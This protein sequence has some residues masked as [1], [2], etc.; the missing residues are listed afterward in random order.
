MEKD[1]DL[2]IFQHQLKFENNEYKLSSIDCIDNYIITGDEKGNIYSYDINQ[3]G[4]ATLDHTQFVQKGKIEQIKCLTPLNLAYI[5]VNG[6]LFG[7]QIPRLDLKF[8]FEHKEMSTIY[9][10]CLN[11]HPQCQN[12]V[13][14]VTKKRKVKCFEYLPEVAKLVEMKIDDLLL[15][16]LTEVMEWY[17]NWF[18]YAV[19]K[20]VF[21][22]NVV[23]G[24]ALNQDIES[25]CIKNVSGSWLI[26][27]NSI[28]LL[29]EQNIPKQQNPIMFSNKPL[30]TLGV[31]KNY[32]ISLHD[33]LIGVFDANDSSQVQE[34][35]LETGSTGKYLT[36]G[37]KRLFYVLS[38][39]SDKKDV[40]SFQIWELKELAFEK[41]INKLL[42]DYKIDEALNI[43]NNN[44]S[45][46][47]EEKP[48]KLEQ[49][50]IDCAWTCVK[51]G[52]FDKASQYAKLTNFNPFE[53]IYLFKNILLP[54]I[55][56]EEFKNSSSSNSLYTIE[57]I[58]MSKENINDA[59]KMLLDLLND[60]RNLF[61]N[62][63]EIPKDNLKKVY[64]TASEL[65]LIN[66]SNSKSDFPLYAIVEMINTTLIKGLVRRKENMK[67]IWD[68]INYEY[69]NCDWDDLESFLI[70]ENTDESKIA[71]AYLNEKRS[72]FEEALK[73]WQEYGNRDNSN[74]ILSKEA[75]ERTKTILKASQDK[76]LFHDYI[77]WV[78][79]KYPKQAFDL[80]L[81]SEI[82]PAEYFFSTII[83]AVEKSTSN[84]T[85][86]EKFLEYY[87]ENNCTNERYH[88]ILAEIYVE[89]LF[90]I[91]KSDIPYESIPVEGN[92]KTNL[93]KL[94]KL[95]K[96][97]NFYN[98]N[99]ILEK[100][101]GSWMIEQEIFLYSKLDLHNE[102]L[103]KLVH[104]GVNQNDFEKVEKYCKDSIQ[105][106][107][108]LFADLFKILSENYNLNNSASK[109]TKN[110]NE[111]KLFENLASIYQK[112]MLNILK[113]CADDNTLDP[114]LVLQQLPNE[115]TISDQ[116]LYEYL[117]K[118][119]KNYTHMS[120]K[121]KVAKSLS[122][123]ALIYKEKEL[124]DVK[125]KSVTISNETHC[126]LCR[127][128]IG[129]AI[130]CVYPN[131]KVYHI[132]CAQNHNVCPTTRV[133][134]TK[135]QLF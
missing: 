24:V 18:S 73:I 125:D 123:M 41:Q 13:L 49:F 60:K 113:K 77:Q 80:F 81:N 57:S 9:R 68:V 54:K 110:E 96:T 101:K 12:Q 23:E 40:S 46:S 21:I 69:F 7:Y 27:T 29:M 102:A 114:F 94:D 97:S 34:I 98:K 103:I 112:E 59:L 37:H 99:H 63:Y 130:F 108:D 132:K 2:G 15:F 134:F 135:K 76:R 79:V 93:D 53:F 33:S 105:E 52:E 107:P 95:L 104:I 30:V 14:I 42:K 86:K 111:R 26:Y 127:K 1:K 82:V 75:M 10:I 120:N 47:N 8:K 72:K 74:A 67:K 36:V 117:T 126:E 38:S 91:Q 121:Y 84:L 61:F 78:L 5:V 4:M 131:M 51:R 128:K 25:S 48:K 116:S 88:T 122:D 55:L 118:I 89:K 58:A 106:R 66:L 119:M 50:F 56:H 45:S 22:N 43:L 70:K 35:Q 71:Y 20:K 16:D 32:I 31:Y 115:W 90:K 3:S 19:K 39:F 65:A 11:E 87:I 109:N 62:N 100:I 6:N 92:L 133:D 129:N 28:G 17:G 64:F 85:L 44:I 83:G 124:I